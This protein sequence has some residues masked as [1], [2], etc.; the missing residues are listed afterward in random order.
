[1]TESSERGWSLPGGG[2]DYGETIENCLLRE[3]REETGLTCRIDRLLYICDRIQDGR[4]VVHLTF[5]VHRDSGE[6]RLG[7]EP[8]AGANK[9]MSIELVPCADIVEYGFSERFRDLLL[10]DFPDSGSYMGPI[11][12]IGL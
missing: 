12:N 2:L 3:M 1:M 8:E 10:N 11:S 6:V 7:Y 5:L 9:I 4:H